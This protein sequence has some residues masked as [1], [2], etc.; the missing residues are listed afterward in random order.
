M[1]IKPTMAVLA[2]TVLLCGCSDRTAGGSST[3]QSVSSAQ[4]VSQGAE[5]SSS[6]KSGAPTVIAP[7]FQ[8][9]S[10][11]S[12]TSVPV[13]SEGMSA[14]SN[15]AV[16]SGNMEVTEEYALSE[17]LY[18]DGIL[19]IKDGG[20]VVV[21]N[22]KTLYVSGAV[23]MSDN[24]KLIIEDGGKLV[25]D[26]DSAKI[27][28]GSVTVNTDFDSLSCEMGMVSSR[29]IPPERK[30]TD[31]VT[32]VGGIVIAN[33]AIKLP[34]EF[35]SHLSLDEVEPEVNAALDEMNSIS[36]HQYINVS[37]YRS[38]YDQQ[39]IFQNYCDI[40]GY[41]EADTFS[42]Q[43]GHSEHQTGLTMDL[44]AFEESYAD[45][46][47]GQWLA[48]NCWRFGFIIRYPKGKDDITGYTYEPWHVRYL[49]KSTAKLVY[50]SG[51]TLEEFLNVEGGKTVID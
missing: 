15:V 44:D 26:A 7:N 48:E 28:G 40:Y 41:D 18:V 27:N 2:L 37:G 14:S 34:P 45:T 30:V 50:D 3:A 46:P 9:T 29:I 35:G 6:E 16:S 17:D 13:T 20:T 47:E 11:T 23:E 8:S 21:G 33:K 42:S 10:E 24:G 4:T 31:G 12:E 39:A 19:T 38:Y 51:L 49:G 36:E 5:Q 43:A 32:T 1:K 22:G 25:M